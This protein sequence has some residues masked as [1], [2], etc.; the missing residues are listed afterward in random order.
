MARAKAISLLQA[1]G[2]KGDLKE[3]YGIVI[4]NIK[5]DTLSGVLKSQNYTGNPA[6]GSVEFKRLANSQANDYGT[7]RAAG[8]GDPLK[9]APVTVKLDKHK[10]IV[11]EI[12]KFDLETYGVPS[13]I[14]RRAANH[15]DTAVTTLD[16]AFFTVADKAATKVTPESSDPMAQLEEL[17]LTLETTKND[18][19]DGVPR[20]MIAVVL[21]SGYYSTVRTKLDSVPNSNVDTAAEEFGTWHGVKIYS[22]LRLPE[23]TK[24]LTMPFGAVGEPVVFNEYGEPMRVPLSNA[25]EVSLFFD[26]GAEALTP[27]LIFKLEEDKV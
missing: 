11:E 22:S 1:A 18:Y 13:I 16:R 5:K 15:I 26:Y 3:I 14:A 23:G 7:A 6:A 21:S 27:D 4:D 20:D 9:G 24:A 10:E 17:I 12:E 25:Y 19:T 8:K 2:E